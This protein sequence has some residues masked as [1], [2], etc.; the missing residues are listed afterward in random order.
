MAI[1]SVDAQELYSEFLDRVRIA[2]ESAV[3]GGDSV[4]SIAERLGA[5][6]SAI[7]SLRNGRYE[8]TITATLLI[9]LDIEFE[10]GIFKK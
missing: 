1:K 3:I 9:A 10:L 2:I 6:R 7:N 8:S 4:A 5:S